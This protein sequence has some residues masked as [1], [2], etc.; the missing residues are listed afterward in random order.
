LFR[1][2]DQATAGDSFVI[3][4]AGKP[5]VKVIALGPPDGSPI[6]RRGFMAGQV[7][8]PDDVDRMGREEVVSLFAGSE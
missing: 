6:K 1:L 3:A 4:K 8:T 5:L 7:A 2:L